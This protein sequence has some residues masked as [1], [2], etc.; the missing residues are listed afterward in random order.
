MYSSTHSTP[1]YYFLLG[2]QLH[3]TSSV[4]EVNSPHS[5]HIEEVPGGS[6]LAL[7]SGW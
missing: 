4:L 7:C 3:D 5:V 1:L 6:V 2:D